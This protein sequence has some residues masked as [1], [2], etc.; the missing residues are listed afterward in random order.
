MTASTAQGLGVLDAALIVVGS[1]V[2]AGIFLVSPYV[3]QHVGSPAGFLG[4]WVLGGGVAL[5]GALSNGELGGLFPRSGGE[6]VYLR[7][8]YGP[9]FGF[10]SGWVSFWIGFPGSIAT[11]AAGLGAT[12]A[13][14][15]G[16]TGTHA[17][18]VIGALAILALTFVNALGLRPGKWT[19]NIL[20]SAKLAV[21]AILLILG[22]AWP[23]PGVPTGLFPF[24]A[25][26]D[27]A[28]GV[29]EA[30]VPVLFAYAGWNAATYVGGEM[31]D[32]TRSLWRAL[33]LGTALCM[34]LYLLINVV[35]LRAMPIAE[36]TGTQEPA[37]VAAVRLG[38]KAAAA[39]LSPLVALCVASSIQASVLVGP[40]IYRAMAV[41]GLFFRA[42]G[43]LHPKTHVPLTA[44]VA[45][46]LVAIVLL[47]SGSFDQLLTFATSPIVA[48]S[49]LTVAAVIVLRLRRPQAVREF[50]VPGGWLLPAL[51]VVVNGWVLWNVLA[52]GAREA[53]IGLAIVASG[54]PA[55]AVFRAL[56]R[57]SSAPSSR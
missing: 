35:Y 17:P 42:F 43:Q 4:A 41:D 47:L 26:G 7:E 55:Y 14:L 1:I 12:L 18:I 22:V 54:V 45:Q 25:G 3:A 36:L 19:Q 31:R 56:T 29:A 44:L 34:L 57:P 46:S 39:V 5:V 49:T 6:Y 51:F 10:L 15:F 2:G 40:R 38:G 52:S 28:H 24:F 23:H 48:F 13:P 32:P 8:A 30:L 11:L 20:S 53:R 21:F 16:W 9:A 27:T 37:R 50:R 33:T